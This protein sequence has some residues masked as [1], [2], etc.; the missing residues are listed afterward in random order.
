MAESLLP[1]LPGQDK[2]SLTRDGTTLH[3]WDWSESEP[4]TAR[5]L[6]ER[7][8]PQAGR[9]DG[10]SGWPKRAAPGRPA[11]SVGR[12]GEPENEAGLSEPRGASPRGRGARVLEA[13]DAGAQTD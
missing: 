5:E 4:E 6:R 9:G 12:R 13:G 2:G 3:K 10:R 11:R 8:G 7:Q 1:P